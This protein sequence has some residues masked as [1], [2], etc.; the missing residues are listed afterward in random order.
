MY[1]HLSYSD[2]TDRFIFCNKVTYERNDT[3]NIAKYAVKKLNETEAEV[4]NKTNDELITETKLVACEFSRDE[5]FSVVVIEDPQVAGDLKRRN[6]EKNLTVEY[7]K[8]SQKD[9]VAAWYYYSNLSPVLM[10]ANNEWRSN[11]NFKENL[12]IIS[13]DDLEPEF[14]FLRPF[15][16]IFLD[17]D[18][19][20]VNQFMFTFRRESGF[21][22]NNS[23]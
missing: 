14:P 10:F 9:Q 21:L 20:M 12:I 3:T 22:V 16:G 1:Q 11:H 2:T 19:I 4:K 23:T 18:L 5:L 17:V 13:Y 15:M 6:M 7:V 8:E